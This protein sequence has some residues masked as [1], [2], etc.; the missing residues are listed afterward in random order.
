MHPEWFPNPEQRRTYYRSY[1]RAYHSLIGTSVDLDSELPKLEAEVSLMELLVHV[2]W[3]LWG[4]I[5][6]ESKK[7]YNPK[8]EDEY[9]YLGYGLRRFE[10]YREKKGAVE[11]MLREMKA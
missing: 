5:Q 7:V 1:L 3:G 10:I 9:D 4:V 6:A 8:D 11:K 2:H